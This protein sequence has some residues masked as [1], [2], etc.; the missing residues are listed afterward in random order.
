MR[1]PDNLFASTPLNILHVLS[2][3]PVFTYSL[4]QKHRMDCVC[5]VTRVM[6]AT[7]FVFSHEQTFSKSCSLCS[8]GS[9]GIKTRQET[10]KSLNKVKGFF[11]FSRRGQKII[12]FFFSELSLLFLFEKKKEFLDCHSIN[13]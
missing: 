13:F 11:F 9:S 8:L 5:Y 12:D 10:G 3:T 4:S 1:P 2:E 6:A 7:L